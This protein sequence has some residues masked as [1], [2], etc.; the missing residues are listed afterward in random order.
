MVDHAVLDHRQIQ[1]D[2]ARFV[3][4]PGTRERY[5]VGFDQGA[6]VSRLSLELAGLDCY[7]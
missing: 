3:L 6:R 7:D 2:N 5:R 1:G 4:V